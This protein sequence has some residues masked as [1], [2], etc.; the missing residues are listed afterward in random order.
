METKFAIIGGSGLYNMPGLEDAAEVSV[1]TPFGKPS[2]AIRLGTLAG[3]R[4]AF[5]ARHGR[6]H[7]LSPSEIPHRANLWALKSL[8]VQWIMSASAVGSLKEACPPGHIVFPDQFF[9]RTKRPCNESTFFGDGLIAHI[10]FGDP[11]CETLRNRA[12]LAAKAEGA[13]ASNGGTYVNMEGPAFSTRA[14]SNFHRQMGWDV[15]GMTNLAEAK[16]AREAE[17]AYATMALVT[18]YDCWHEEEVTVDLVIKQLHTNAALAARILARVLREWDD[19]AK[20]K[21]HTALTSAVYTP[22][23]AWPEARVKA[24]APILAR[25]KALRA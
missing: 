25:L 21:A 24:L 3:R 2:D 12:Y 19:G 16:L 13:Q 22:F 23:E 20:S 17:M 10:S 15:I 8:G 7:G 9:D 5:L 18:D 11:V 1:E 14:E 4:V 6:T